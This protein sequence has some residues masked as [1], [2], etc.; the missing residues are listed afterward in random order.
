VSD[1]E[2]I[3]L[4]RLT[5]A[6]E[7][8]H[9]GI[10][11]RDLRT[12][13][14][15]RTPMVD[16]MFGFA[17]G[18]VGPD[19]G[20]F[21]ARIHPDDRIAIQRNIERAGSSG[22][23]ADLTFRVRIPDGTERWI[24]G[25]AELVGDEAG[26]PARLLAVLR[27]VTDQHQA[28]E[29]LRESEAEFR[30]IFEMAGRGKALADA[31]GRLLKV[32]RALC[33]MT[34]YSPD[35]LCAM[36]IRD[37][38][39]PDDWANDAALLRRLTAGEVLSIDREKRYIRRDGRIIWIRVAT[40]MLA[41]G[42]GKPPRLAAVIEDITAQ[43]KA[44]LALAEETRRLD[45]LNRTGATLASELD[46]ER[47]VQVV[48]DSGVALSGAAFGA[49]FYNVVDE[50]NESYTLYALSGAPRE[51]FARFP[52]PRNT[53]VFGPTF[54][55]AG[56]VRSDD[57]TRD[58][59]YG[60]NAPYH[61]MPAGHLPV[62]SYL[63]VP[64][65]SRSGE[66]LGGLFFGHPEPGV[67]TENTERLLT[68]VAA[69][70]SI[71]IDN[72]RL[73]Q[74]AQKEIAERTRAEQR[75]VMLAGEVDHRAKNMLALMQ[76]MVRL[77]KASTTAEYVSLLTGRINALAQTHALLAASRW[78]GAD[79]AR[80]VAAELRPYH[81]D[82]RA[83]VAVAGPTIQL[84]P[85]AAQSLA[86]AVHELVTNAVKYGALSTSTGHVAIAWQH[87]DADG[88]RLEWQER[89][90]PP[91]RAP[92]RQ[93]FGTTAIERMIS[94][95]LGGAVR[96]DWLEDGLRCELTFPRA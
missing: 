79:L 13:L 43:K 57:I 85:A 75:L 41:G 22:H 10:W 5:A 54:A 90:G 18:E 38:T 63:A 6:L 11:E 21:L 34:G 30:A 64:V 88:I 14:S 86:I 87:G 80:I 37:L 76:A 70:A 53:A 95:Q 8:A 68:A 26:R 93:G 71:A 16:A 45:I 74:A 25:R 55:G 73:Y 12:N 46:L 39:H 61:G 44:S 56:V 36:T 2:D 91:V 52:M 89:G 42:E 66:V 17:P 59:R 62:R 58:P 28:Q 48:T 19:A 9:T 69:Q 96:F 15:L 35:D 33:E 81:A 67:F 92:A 4:E 27:D 1:T 84:G 47:L 3:G 77:T 20:P 32:N 50:K 78:S 94:Q 60:K 31:S 51:A 82:G 24:A 72:A 49:F 40:V 7:I 83:Q 29:A 23:L 65:I